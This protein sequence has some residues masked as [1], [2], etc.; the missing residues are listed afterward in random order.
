MSL[1]EVVRAVA[2]RAPYLVRR[3]LATTPGVRHLASMSLDLLTRAGTNEVVKLRHVGGYGMRLNP[4]VHRAM[5]VGTYEPQVAKAI[6]RY[7]VS[8]AYCVDIGAHIGYFVLHMAQRV[9]ASGRVWAF[10]AAPGPAR[11]LAENVAINGLE[12]VV[13]VEQAAV[14]ETT[15]TA[16]LHVAGDPFD[17]IAS[18]SADG[19][20]SW[21]RARG[22]AVTVPAV[23]LDD[24]LR[25][26]PRLNLVV[27]DV[28]GAEGL[29][30]AG[31]RGLLARHRPTLVVEMHT[32]PGSTHLRAEAELTAAGYRL[33]VIDREHGDAA[34]HVLARPVELLPSP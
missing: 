21:G 7:A 2:Q 20:A 34:Y 24:F 32:L 11:V 15:G 6:A 1:R 30:L 19:L 27:I 14:S 28:E 16:Q 22:T 12:G 8:G 4:R 25:D 29:V 13:R 10:E 17:A 26:T 31:M 5:M 18:L 9:G 33:D 3:F 23:A